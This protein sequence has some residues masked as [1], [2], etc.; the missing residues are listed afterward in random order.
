MPLTMIQ[1]LE[2]ES[3][4][5]ADWG[6]FCGWS[7]RRD[8]SGDCCDLPWLPTAPVH[9]WWY[10]DYPQPPPV[11]LELDGWTRQWVQLLPMLFPIAPNCHCFKD[12]ILE[13]QYLQFKIIFWNQTGTRFWTLKLGQ[14]KMDGLDNEFNCCQCRFPLPPTATALGVNVFRQAKK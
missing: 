2:K 13:L 8:C 1:N 4:R 11:L 9:C 6:T 12:K 5:V 3:T 10:Q 7:I 14:D